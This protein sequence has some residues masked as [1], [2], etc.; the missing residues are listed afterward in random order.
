[1]KSGA[2]LS[3]LL[4]QRIMGH[5]GK[6]AKQNGSF[7]FGLNEVNVFHSRVNIQLGGM[8]S[9][10]SGLVLMVGKNPQDALGKGKEKAEFT[11]EPQPPS[12]FKGSEE[13][14]NDMNFGTA[15]P[16]DPNRDFSGSLD[17]D[18]APKIPSN[19]YT[20]PSVPNLNATYSPTLTEQIKARIELRKQNIEPVTP[21][22]QH[23]EP[24]HVGENVDALSK[25]MQMAG[26]AVIPVAQGYA[27]Y[28]L[29]PTPQNFAAIG[30]IS[31]GAHEALRIKTHDLQD[32]AHYMKES[33]PAGMH[34]SQHPAS[35]EEGFEVAGLKTSRDF[36]KHSASLSAMGEE[37]DPETLYARSKSSSSLSTLT[38]KDLDAEFRDMLQSADLSRAK[39]VSDPTTLN[40]SDPLSVFEGIDRPKANSA[41][42]VL[43]VNHSTSE[44]ASNLTLTEEVLKS[45]L[46]ST[47]VLTNTK[48]FMAPSIAE[49]L[50]KASNAENILS[51]ISIWMTQ[52]WASAATILLSVTLRN[53]LP[54]LL[55]RFPQESAFAVEYPRLY[56][57]L[58]GACELANDQKRTDKLMLYISLY[59]AICLLFLTGNVLKLIAIIKCAHAL[60]NEEDN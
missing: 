21:S 31:V 59:I 60:I 38:E 53:G 37:S 27:Q 14:R 7:L 58:Q 50:T 4:E 6:K 11:E 56:A 15:E 41:P 10:P 46:N 18:L 22:F 1:M 44:S 26:D 40:R 47:T 8:A 25:G 29:P 5:N 43:Q 51:N 20:V 12:L 49:S 16:Y 3:S 48:S 36:L 54:A 55:R 13:G 17:P 24:V 52:L 32:Q 33:V 28:S 30:T 39:A 42:T 19:T 57:R 9:F 45:Q 2:E 23:S 35:I 34:D